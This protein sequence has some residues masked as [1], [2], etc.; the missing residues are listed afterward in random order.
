MRESMRLRFWKKSSRNRPYGCLR[1]YAPEMSVGLPPFLEYSEGISREDAYAAYVDLYHA[2]GS[3]VDE[4]HDLTRRLATAQTELAEKTRFF[5]C[6]LRELDDIC[7]SE[8]ADAE[9]A[10]E[11]T[12]KVPCEHCKASAMRNAAKHDFRVGLQTELKQIHTR[13]DQLAQPDV[14]CRDLRIKLH[15]Y[16]HNYPDNYKGYRIKK[17]TQ[18][19]ND[20]WDE[21]SKERKIRH[22][23]ELEL[24]QLWLKFHAIKAENAALTQER[25][26]AWDERNKERMRLNQ[27]EVELSQLWTKYLAIKAENA[28]LSSPP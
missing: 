25:N 24:S 5:D 16:E 11:P 7:D 26:D 28:A 18:E 13:L 22:Q 9:E 14:E 1:A 4:I 6:K 3:K 10:R 23:I 8:K 12:Q 20:A 15:Q 2:F 27:I 21:T 19:R 17:L